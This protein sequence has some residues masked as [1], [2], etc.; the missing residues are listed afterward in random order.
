MIFVEQAA[1]CVNVDDLANELV[2]PDLGTSQ[3]LDLQRC[4]LQDQRI[5]LLLT[6]LEDL[7]YE[8]VARI[9]GVPIGTVRSGAEKRHDPDC[10]PLQRG[11]S[12]VI[13]LQD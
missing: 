3:S 4:L 2:A 11:R 7:G 8:E 12:S 6:S 5:V 10:Y 13:L 9:T 1:I